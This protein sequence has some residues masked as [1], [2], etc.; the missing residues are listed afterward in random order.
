MPLEPGDAREL[1]LRLRLDEPERAVDADRVVARV[2]DDHEAPRAAIERRPSRMADEHARKAATTGV[3]MRLD[4]LEAREPRAVGDDA[5]RGDEHPV[6]EGPEPGRVAPVAELSER[7]NLAGEE[8]LGDVLVGRIDA[9][10][11]QRE[12][13]PPVGVAL[14]G[15]Q[16]RFG[17]TSGRPE[18][19]PP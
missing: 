8:L 18:R 14:E 10:D 13:L 5:E 9:R 11:V 7:R 17:R 3:G 16:L 19:T 4:R 2:G 6:L 15:S 12:C 1:H